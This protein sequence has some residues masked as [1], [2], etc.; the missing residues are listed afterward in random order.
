[1]V[2]LQV[3]D[4]LEKIRLA[5]TS[6][7]STG[8]SGTNVSSSNDRPPEPPIFYVHPHV[9]EVCIMPNAGKSH[10]NSNININMT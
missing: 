1:M 5:S 9:M 4:H 3:T 2:Y 10:I 8:G 7:A 6:A